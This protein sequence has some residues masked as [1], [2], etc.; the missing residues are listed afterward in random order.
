MNTND[1]KRIIK[2]YNR[3]AK[4][5]LEYEILFHLAWKDSVEVATR[6]KLFS[7][8]NSL[9]ATC[10]EHLVNHAVKTY[11]NTGPLFRRSFQ[12]GRLIRAIITYV[13]FFCIMQDYW[14]QGTIST[15]RYGDWFKSSKATTFC[16]FRVPIEYCLASET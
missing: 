2:K 5:L 3:L 9:A 15:L 10:L 13:S 11:P 8:V 4:V 16:S 6:C 12:K 7:C 14:L 1:A